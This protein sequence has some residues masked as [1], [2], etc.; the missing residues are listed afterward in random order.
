[1]F[2]AI[3]ILL[4]L[5]LLNGI[6]AMSELAM[7]TSRQSRLQQAAEG[8]DGGA[9]MA[10]KLAR[11]PTRF[12][13]TV[14]VGITLIGIMAGAFGEKALS[15]HV[16]EL[17]AGVPALEKHSDTIAM[18]LV[19]LLITYFSLVLGELVP[20][21]LALAFPET[22][23]ARIARPLN[24][25]S[26][27]AAAPV[28]VLTVSTEAILA[29]LRVKPREG[30]D[31]SE[32]DVKSLVS[33]ATTTG[34]FSPFEH[35]LFQRTFRL[36]DIKVG[37]LM[38]PRTGVVWLDERATTEEVRVTIGTSPHSHFPVARGSLDSVI[39]VVHIKDLISYGLM[40]GREF[41]V[42]VVA[43]EPLFVPE[44]T[45]ALAMLDQFQRSKVHIAVV[46]NEYGGMEGLVTLNDVVQAL[47]G[48]LGRRGDDGKAQATQREDGS[49]LLDGSL[50]LHEMA[51]ALGFS[52]E[53]EESLPSVNTVSGLVMSVLG[54]IPKAGD[55]ADWSSLTLEVMDMDGARV[56]KVL[57]VKRPT[58][59]QSE[60][61]G[62]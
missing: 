24:V 8:G 34:V 60:H 56:D 19:V 3:A 57:A 52:A 31:V 27:V 54:R 62:E 45:T 51:V 48:N 36:G 42:S 17:V 46:V 32:E 38:V 47:V 49:W 5:L 50:S 53:M 21:R 39:G 58:V 40:S 9:A 20:K 14:Q 55:R 41:R 29:V 1:M 4:V 7:M 10:L 23:A 35:A 11:Q 30:E 2:I 44:T 25:L 28:K 13:S 18:V 26:V 22:I 43:Q 61:G 37:A 6:F 59:D 16:Q 33:R 15:G 12:L